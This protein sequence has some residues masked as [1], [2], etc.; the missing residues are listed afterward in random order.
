M[1]ELVAF[2]GFAIAVI[3]I[4]AF[5]VDRARQKREKLIALLRDTYRAALCGDCDGQLQ[6]F[7]TMVDGKTVVPRQRGC[8]G[9]LGDLH[10]RVAA[11][12]E[13]S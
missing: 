1:I 7:A 2:V 8:S 13:K 3:A 4:A 11:V 12:L 10:A 6:K 5:V 9:C